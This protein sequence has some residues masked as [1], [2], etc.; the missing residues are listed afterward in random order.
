MKLYN[1]PW[2]PYPRRLTHYLGEKNISDIELVPV[3]FPHKPERWPPNFLN[4]L[5]AAHSL[6]VL[7]TETGA[8]IGQSIAILEYL[9]ERYPKPNLIGK[10][11]EA[12]AATREMIAII[13][14]ATSFFGLWA[15]HGSRVNA[16]REKLSFEAANIGAKRFTSKLHVAEQKVRGPFLLGDTLTIA[17][18]VALALVEFADQFYGVPLPNECPKLVDWY[19]KLSLRPGYVPPEYPPEM[20]SVAHG[21]PEHTRTGLRLTEHG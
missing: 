8:R 16:A 13:D 2:G 5:N 3:E 10:T 4:S 19:T 21:L 6:P 12:R 18:C 9:E 11:P 1:F 15:R 20:L 7:E 14:E 17:D